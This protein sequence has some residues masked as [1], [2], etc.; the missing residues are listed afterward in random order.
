MP[1]GQLLVEVKCSLL[2]PAFKEGARDFP[3]EAVCI[4]LQEHGGVEDAEEQPHGE[5][6]RGVGRYR[7]ADAAV[8]RAGGQIIVVASFKALKW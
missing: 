7:G 3:A 6:H 2:L 4:G 1:S 8:G 5:Q